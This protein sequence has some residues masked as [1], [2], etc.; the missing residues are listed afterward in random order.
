MASSELV[1]TPPA[2]RTKAFHKGSHVYDT[3]QMG[4]ADEGA[5]LLDAT[6]S[7]N[8]NTGHDYGTD[9]SSAQKR[10]LI[11]YLKTR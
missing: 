1:S 10:D 2:E 11:E 4:F 6:A 9:L 7:G 5:Y 8:G 3:L